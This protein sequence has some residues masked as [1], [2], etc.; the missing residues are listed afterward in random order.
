MHAGEKLAGG[1][2]QSIIPLGGEGR[3]HLLYRFVSRKCQPST[4][5]VN[6][7]APRGEIGRVF[8]LLVS[9]S[10]YLFDKVF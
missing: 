1:N 6:N 2:S 10:S 5:Q 4:G 7:D 3:G 9:L 8:D